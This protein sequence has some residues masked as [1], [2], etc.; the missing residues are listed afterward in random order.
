MIKNCFI[1]R[2]FNELQI[3]DVFKFSSVYDSDIPNKFYTV[4]SKDELNTKIQ[5]TYGNVIQTIKINRNSI[6]ETM[7]Y[8][9]RKR[10]TN[11]KQIK[12]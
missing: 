7:V 12:P 8:P 2:F 11:E 5:N 3:G 1:F 4:I 6:K 9:Y 10:L